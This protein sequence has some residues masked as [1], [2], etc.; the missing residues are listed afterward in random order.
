VK[1]GDREILLTGSLVAQEGDET[2]DIE[3]EDLSFHITFE[4]VAGSPVGSVMKTEGKTLIICLQNFDNVLGSA[5]FSDVGT[6]RGKRLFLALY[7]SIVGEKN[8]IRFVSYT[9]STKESDGKP[10]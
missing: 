1:A 9:F 5:W 6:T 8:P 10:T 4:K 7:I 3:F 2:L